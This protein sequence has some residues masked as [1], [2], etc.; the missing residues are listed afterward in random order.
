MDAK[1]ADHKEVV[2]QQ[3]A[4]ALHVLQEVHPL[5]ESAVVGKLLDNSRA[6]MSYKVV[7]EFKYTFKSSNEKPIVILII[8]E[9]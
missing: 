7:N 3:E 8:K 1:V 4:Q 6:Q 2:L 9:L 5:S